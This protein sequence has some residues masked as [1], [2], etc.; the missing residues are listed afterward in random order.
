MVPSMFGFLSD[1]M[2]IIGS[3]VAWLIKKK[4]TAPRLRWRKQQ[5][6]TLLQKLFS[7]TK[8]NRPPYQAR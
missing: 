8:I 3:M 4:L 1:G 5:K 6:V 2:R 7:G